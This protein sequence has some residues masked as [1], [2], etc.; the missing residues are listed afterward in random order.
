MMKVLFFTASWCGNCRAIKP[1][2]EK[3]APEKGVDVKY[4]DC[5]SDEGI[6]MCEDWHVRNLPTLILVDENGNEVKRAVGSTAWKEINE[7]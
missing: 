7:K 1:L 5:D 4:V 3:E 6:V 2:V